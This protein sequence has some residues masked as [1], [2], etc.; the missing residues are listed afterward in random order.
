MKLSDIA[1]Q[2]GHSHSHIALLARDL[3][4]PG[5]RKTKGGHWRVANTDRLKWW[6]MENKKGNRTKPK[7]GSGPKISPL[8]HL[9]AAENQL[10][11][12]GIFSGAVNFDEAKASLE[13]LEFLTPRVRG[14]MREAEYK[15]AKLIAQKELLKK[16]G[17]KAIGVK[18]TRGGIDH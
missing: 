6:I 9:A 13:I 2:T 12:H 18:G 8:I 1:K 3:E 10:T 17:V 14:I 7:Y 16:H 11:H 5:C 15:I 4:I